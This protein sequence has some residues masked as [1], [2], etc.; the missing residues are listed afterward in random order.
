MVHKECVDAGLGCFSAFLSSQIC[1]NIPACLWHALWQFSAVDQDSRCCIVRGEKHPDP[2]SF[3]YPY[4]MQVCWDRIVARD[5][6]ANRHSHGSMAWTLVV[7]CTPWSALGWKKCCQAWWSRTAKKVAANVAL[8]DIP[9][10]LAKEWSCGTQTLT[11]KMPGMGT[12]LP[13]CIQMELKKCHKIKLN[14]RLITCNNT[15][16][17]V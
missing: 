8:C 10:S 16:L 9:S 12:T 7:C 1:V 3:P 2:Q 17:I 15:Y 5:T 13:G 4:E 6:S 11:Q 14:R